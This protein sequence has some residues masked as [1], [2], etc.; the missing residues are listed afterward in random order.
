MCLGP[1]YVAGKK[2]TQYPIPNEIYNLASEALELARNHCP[3]LKSTRKIYQCMLNYYKEGSR[4]S[5]HDERYS[6]G[7]VVSFSVGASA[8]F[9]YKNSWKKTLPYK[10]QTLDSGDVFV[11]G[12]SSR[13]IVHGVKNVRIPSTPTYLDLNGR[14]NFNVRE[15]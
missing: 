11:F 14:I 2:V 1:S 6:R 15:K 8:D 3:N 4:L 5:A 9:F 7:A 13:G 10:T 12:G